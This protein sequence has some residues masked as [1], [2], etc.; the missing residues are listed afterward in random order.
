MTALEKMT[1]WLQTFPLWQEE[2]LSVDYVDALPGNAGLYPEG[3]EQVS[4][5][6]DVLGNVTVEN[7]LHFVLYRVTAGQQD[8]RENSLWL[9]ELQSWVQQQ[10]AAGLVPSFGDVP[11]RERIS[12]QKGKLKSASQT[13]TGKYTVNLTVE[14]TKQYEK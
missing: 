14:F 13:G 11:H 3:L 9:L 8:N 12:A 4:R 1:T 6:E 7:R 5:R 10:S 2:S